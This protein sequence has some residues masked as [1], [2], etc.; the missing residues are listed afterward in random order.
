MELFAV[1]VGGRGSCSTSVL[2]CLKKLGFNNILV[3]N[4]IKKISKSSMECS[5]CIC[6]QEIT[7]KGLLL[8]NFKSKTLKETC[9]SASP[10]PY[11]KQNTNPVS[12]ANSV[13][14]VG[15]INKGN[16]GYANSILQ[17]LNI[18]PSLW[19]DSLQNQTISLPCYELLVSTWLLKRIPLNLLIHQI[20][21]GP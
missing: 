6:W 15:F 3:R 2:C 4:N 11:L 19:T 9:N 18:M 20:F 12:K 13:C 14:H 10:R 17:V 5:F 1:E 7:K 16:T 21:Y 8:L